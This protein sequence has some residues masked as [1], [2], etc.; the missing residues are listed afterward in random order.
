MRSRANTSARLWLSL[1]LDGE[2]LYCTPSTKPHLQ[3]RNDTYLLN[4]F[5]HKLPCWRVWTTGFATH[6][7]MACALR[8]QD[9]WSPSWHTPGLFGRFCSHLQVAPWRG[10]E[11]VWLQICV[12]GVTLKKVTIGV[13]LKG[14][15]IKVSF[16]NPQCKI[17]SDFTGELHFPA[18]S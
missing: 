13:L 6:G 7:D 1:Y 18:T 4:V 5:I 2:F 11:M 17:C 10:F 16:G 14:D 3:V 9:A 15:L 8:W 12:W